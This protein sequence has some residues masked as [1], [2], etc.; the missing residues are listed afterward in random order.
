LVDAALL[1]MGARAEGVIQSTA[2]SSYC[3]RQNWNLALSPSPQN[4]TDAPRW[5]IYVD[6]GGTFTDLV[7]RAPDG[8]LLT[9]KLLSSAPEHYADAA[10]EGI[11]RLLGLDSQ[12]RLDSGQ[13]EVVKVGTTVATNALLE[14][15]GEPTLLAITQ[16]FGD[17]LRIGYQNRP[18]L[19]TRE[20]ILPEL[21]YCRVLE[22]DERIAAD[23]S[24]GSHPVFDHEC[25]S[26]LFS[27]LFEDHACN[28]IARD[29]GRDRHDNGDVARRPIL[30]GGGCERGEQDRCA[31]DC[32]HGGAAKYGVHCFLQLDVF[33]KQFAKY[34]K[35][36]FVLRLS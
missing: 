1:A 36:N 4:H 22:I 14:R 5:Q 28:E 12:A 19:F 23:G 3:R 26:K 11:R 21:L 32:T 34:R 10:V 7:A 2:L 29:T 13:I 27:H 15:K 30:R 33:L 20:I 16:G 25:L 17:A 6:R 18:H 31:Q 35:Q 9:Q 24:A 8:R